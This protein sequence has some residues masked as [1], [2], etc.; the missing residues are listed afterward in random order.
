[1]VAITGHR[2]E[3]NGVGGSERPT[4]HTHQKLIKVTPPPP[5]GKTHIR[6]H[7]GHIS[8]WEANTHT[9]AHALLLFLPIE[10]LVRE[11]DKQDVCTVGVGGWRASILITHARPY[12]LNQ[13]AS[14]SVIPENC[15]TVHD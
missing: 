14:I 11:W 7:A 13:I 3:Y 4:A 15:R 6:I 2:M 1:M 5:R 12:I 9:S 10:I 8:W